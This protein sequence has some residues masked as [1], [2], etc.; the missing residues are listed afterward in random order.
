MKFSIDA[1]PRF[2]LRA[3]VLGVAVAVLLTVSVVF[4]WT[5]PTQSPPNS[6]GGLA[7]GTGANAQNIGIGTATPTEK[8]QI[9]ENIGGGASGDRYISIGAPDANTAGITISN[10]QSGGTRGSIALDFSDQTLNIKSTEAIS[11]ST[12]TSDEHI[13]VKKNGNV[14]VGTAYD[15]LSGALTDMDPLAKLHVYGGGIVIGETPQ[16]GVWNSRLSGANNIKSN[17]D[18]NGIGSGI[19]YPAMTIVGDGLPVIAY[20][21][22]SNNL[23]TAHC[24]D[25]LCKSANIQMVDSSGALNPNAGISIATASD[26]YPIIAY[27][28][29]NNVYVVKCK[30]YTCD[31][32]DGPYQITTNSVGVPGAQS[33]TSITT[34]SNGNPIIAFHDKSPVN[35]LSIIS[36]TTTGQPPANCST[37]SAQIDIDLNPALYASLAIGIDRYPI[38][39][40]MDGSFALKVAHCNQ[41]TCSSGAIDLININTGNSQTQYASLSI[42]RDGLPIMAYYNLTA[43][44]PQI[45]HCNTISCSSFAQKNISVT[46]GISD[47]A[48]ASLTIGADGLPIV[49][50]YEVT[51]QNL[52]VAKCG[53][54]TCDT[55]IA[56]VSVVADFDP[57]L[58]AG[59]YTAIAIGA[60]GLPVISYADASGDLKV[61]HCGSDNCLTYWTR[62]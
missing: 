38:I 21:D 6:S 14:G 24:K 45:V 23:V 49:A 35:S 57:G 61:G 32:V 7:V 59:T 46:S 62:R 1:I 5:N 22:S 56:P 34:S 30:S 60:D 52:R 41:D 48:Y 9:Y 20:M 50:Y 47:G 11:V 27:Y 3:E 19:K 13:R 37:A 44:D 51:N 36:C 33:F 26:W 42:G 28:R 18:E 2:L 17:L 53:D 10:Q 25:I 43:G 15:P 55:T 12:N 16:R 31:Q 40:Y 29:S 58:A 39:S 4:G 54:P 8:L